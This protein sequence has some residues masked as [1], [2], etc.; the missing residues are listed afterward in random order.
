M[1]D[2]AKDASSSSRTQCIAV[3]CPDDVP[4]P[5][6]K[7]DKGSLIPQL[8]PTATAGCAGP[9]CP[10]E[11]GRDPKANPNRL[12]GWVEACEEFNYIAVFVCDAELVPAS[13]GREQDVQDDIYVDKYEVFDILC[14][15]ALQCNES[16]V[17]IAKA[18]ALHIRSV[19]EEVFLRD[20]RCLHSLAQQADELVWHGLLDDAM[21]YA[22][23]NDAMVCGQRQELYAKAL[24][25]Q[26]SRLHVWWIQ[27][28][29]RLEQL[30]QV[31]AP[32]TT[33]ELRSE[34]LPLISSSSTTIG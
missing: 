15:G 13:C 2:N 9:F 20:R 31:A 26:L 5:R 10:T 28:W 27:E 18:D 19:A 32:Q 14:S 25:Q 8:T 11:V 3:P 34:D 22:K 30:T 16:G 12:R 17:S 24:K 23:S 6:W 29:H 1:M 33:H 21:A 7:R 4:T